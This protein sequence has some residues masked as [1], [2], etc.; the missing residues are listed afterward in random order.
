MFCL[1][2]GRLARM[3][4]SVRV[5]KMF[6]V[7]GLINKILIINNLNCKILYTNFN[8]F[9]KQFIIQNFYVKNLNVGL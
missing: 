7:V 3:D 2:I 6:P 9:Y 5:S 1:E 4:Q 8:S